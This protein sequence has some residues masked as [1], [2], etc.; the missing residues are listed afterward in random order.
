VVPASLMANINI[1]RS[2][3]LLSRLRGSLSDSAAITPSNSLTTVESLQKI[4]LLNS[5][6]AETLRMY[7][8]AYITRCSPH[9]DIPIGRWTLPRDEVTMVSTYTAHHSEEYW[10][11]KGGQYPVGKFWA[12]RF[13]ID[14]KDPMSGPLRKDIDIPSRKPF[15][16]LAPNDEPVFSTQ[17]LDGIWIPYGGKCLLTSLSLDSLT[18]RILGGYGACP[19]RIF[20]KKLILYLS[21]L[22]ATRYDVEVLP[23][24]IQ[25]DTEKFGLGGQFPKGKVAFRIRQRE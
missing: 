22:M 18:H 10:N 16:D 17:G 7:S 21:A 5:I 14:P 19:G 15:K 3:S 12:E 24:E 25:M 11:T 4:P 9:T 13:L 20:A 6:Y 2:P 8:Q 23:R 1:F